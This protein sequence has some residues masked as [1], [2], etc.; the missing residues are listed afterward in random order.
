MPGRPA[1]G[2]KRPPARRLPPRPAWVTGL[3]AG[4]V[5]VVAAGWLRYADRLAGPL[6]P[7]G[8]RLFSTDRVGPQ[9][10]WLRFPG[11]V[12][13][14]VCVAAACW[15]A[16]RGHPTA[17]RL[18]TTAVAGGVAA[19]LYF[20][21][22]SW[23]A[24]YNSFTPH[25]TAHAALS[26]AL[27]FAAPTTALLTATAA[28]TALGKGAARIPFRGRLVLT[29][30]ATSAALLALAVFLLRKVQYQ[31]GDIEIVYWVA[32]S[33][34]A[35][36]VGLLTGLLTRLTAD[37]A[38]RPVEAIR[39]RLAHITSH[40]LDQRVPVPPTDDAIA[41]LA[42]TTNDTLDRLEQS[43]VRQR[44]FVADAAHELRSP[45]AA[46]RAQL[47]SALRHP[48]GVDWPAVVRG[49]AADVV[50]LQALADDLLL[51]AQLDGTH[52][53]GT[54][55]VDL[56]ALAEDL[57]REHRHLPVAHGLGLTCAAPP[58]ALVR[59][60]AGQLERLLRNLLGNACRHA[61]HRVTL[62][63]TLPVTLSATD[64]GT[65]VVEVTD[66]GPGIPPADRERVFERFTRLD[67][68]RA[69]ADGGAGLGLPIARDIAT[70]H[71]GT[72]LVTDTDTTETTTST[73]GP[74]DEGGERPTGARLLL[75][76]PRHP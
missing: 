30:A 46:V 76:L 64:P 29:A 59:G 16:T 33:T 75:S 47:E 23:V 67:E 13:A 11:L 55:T 21:Q 28:W 2:S 19:A 43:A 54:E 38:L 1:A 52:E 49:A 69:R 73:T 45:L 37:H 44:R 8:P 24:R 71:G 10:E 53:A 15:P 42:L 3:V 22:L 36:A 18:R 56:S 41:R 70:R 48:R 32:L 63:V 58:G 66:D 17:V 26:W 9:I 50:R 20:P 4:L 57:V 51:L 68:A 7:L 31:W 35:P 27:K 65:V 61:R 6:P 60:H 72:L 5:V 40:S 74:D 12:L 25:E 34:G 14:A 62:T 39:R